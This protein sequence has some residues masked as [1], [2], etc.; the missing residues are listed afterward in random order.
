[1][2]VDHLYLMSAHWVSWVGGE[3]ISL[4]VLLGWQRWRW[5]K[6][7]Q[8]AAHTECKLIHH[9]L[10]V[11]YISYINT[12]QFL[13]FQ[14]SSGHSVISN[15][16]RPHGLQH[17]RLPC[18]SPPPRACSNSCPSSWWCH[19]T[20]SFSNIPFSSCLQSFP[21]SGSF[22]GSQFFASGGRSMVAAASALQNTWVHKLS[23]PDDESLNVQCLGFFLSQM[24]GLN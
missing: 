11:Y 21:A 12:S 23:N 20:I 22:P 24:R 16:L 3:G 6:C 17:S 7:R 8:E 19:A 15:L 5:W 18:P 2:K 9:S 4:A 14:F 10:Y 1:M 13:I